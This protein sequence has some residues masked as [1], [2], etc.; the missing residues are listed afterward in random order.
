[1]M[2][3]NAATPSLQLP[4]IAL[5]SQKTFADNPTTHTDAL[6]LSQILVLLLPLQCLS[7]GSV[8]AQGQPCLT[9]IASSSHKKRNEGARWAAYMDN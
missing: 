2:P 3:Q 4:K 9:Y 8:T 7:P 1:M 5:P 6:C